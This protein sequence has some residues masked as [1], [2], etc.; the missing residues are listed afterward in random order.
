MKQM[1]KVGF[2]LNLASI[3]VITLIGYFWIPIVWGT[4]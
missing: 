4:K 3:A 2:F 1:I